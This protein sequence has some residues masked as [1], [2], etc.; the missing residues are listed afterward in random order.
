MFSNTL[1]WSGPGHKATFLFF[2]CCVEFYYEQGWAGY[3][4]IGCRKSPPSGKLSPGK[5]PPGKDPPGKM[6]PEKIP[7]KENSPP[8]KTS[9][10]E[11]YPPENS[12]P[13][14]TPTM[15]ITSPPRKISPKK[16]SPIQKKFRDI[17]KSFDTSF[18]TLFIYLL[19]LLQIFMEYLILY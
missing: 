12:P 11:N 13:R 10:L 14:K 2:Y 16:S 15:E 18:G 19:Y 3:L 6:P 4:F 9:P 8:R 1:I 5:F 17:S 7:P